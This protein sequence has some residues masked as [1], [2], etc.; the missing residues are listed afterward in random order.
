MLQPALVDQAQAIAAIQQSPQDVQGEQTL[1]RHRIVG[2]E[3]Q[4]QW[5]EA[6]EL[7][8]RRHVR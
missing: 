2:T 7:A 8:T 4:P 5:R 6:I 3:L 1:Y